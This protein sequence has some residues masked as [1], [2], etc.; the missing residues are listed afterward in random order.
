MN[1]GQWFPPK[2]EL[3]NPESPKIEVIVDTSHKPKYHQVF[4]NFLQ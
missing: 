2:F 4:G 3:S 1:V